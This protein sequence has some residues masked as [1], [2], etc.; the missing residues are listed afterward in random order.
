MAA[1]GSDATACSRED[2]RPLSAHLHHSR[3]HRQMAQVA[4][5]PT[6]GRL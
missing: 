4:P 3:E 5:E 1:L 2:Q 6:F